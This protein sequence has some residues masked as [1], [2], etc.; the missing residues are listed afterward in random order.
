LADALRRALAALDP[1]PAE[2]F[3]LVHLDGWAVTDA[4]AHLGLSAN[5]AGVLLHRTRA[6]LRELL[7]AFDPN[8]GV[9]RE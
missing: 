2:L 1:R 3:A 4:A 7:K 8:P 5:H 9:P 6:K